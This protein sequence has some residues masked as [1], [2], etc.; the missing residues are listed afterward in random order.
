[1][2]ICVYIYIYI[3]FLF[4]LFSFFFCKGIR[5]NESACLCCD[6][7]NDNMHD[8]DNCN[9]D[10]T[11]WS[12]TTDQD[13][14]AEVQQCDI[15]VV[16][17]NKDVLKMLSASMIF[18]K[19]PSGYRGRALNE[20]FPRLNLLKGDRVEPSE[21]LR[22]THALDEICKFPCK[23]KFWRCSSERRLLRKNILFCGFLV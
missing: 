4:L 6:A 15:D 18:D 9:L 3:I 5:S 14:A 16:V 22:D 2:R 21:F 11:G 17:P 12:I 20:D 19:R 7:T 10:N 13:W 23:L 1:M 8:Y